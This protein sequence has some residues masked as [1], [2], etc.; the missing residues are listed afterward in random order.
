[1]ACFKERKPASRQNLWCL[2][3]DGCFEEFRNLKDGA[4]FP[5][6]MADNLTYV[7]G[8]AKYN[9]YKYVPW[10]RIDEVMPYLIR[11]AQVCHSPGSPHKRVKTHIAC[12]FMSWTICCCLGYSVFS[13]VTKKNPL[14]V[15]CCSNG[16]SSAEEDLP[17][18]L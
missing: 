15:L 1:M 17:M 2:F 7:L 11:R 13:T 14:L 9:A 4:C 8:S 12:Y 10:G 5:A 18:I 16:V 3:A 6:G